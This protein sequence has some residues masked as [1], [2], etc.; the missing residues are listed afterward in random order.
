MRSSDRRKMQIC[1]KSKEQFRM[2]ITSLFCLTG[3]YN[4]CDKEKCNAVGENLRLSSSTQQFQYF[5]QQCQLH[6]NSILIENCQQ[7]SY[8]VIYK[9]NIAVTKPLTVVHSI[10][11]C[12][13]S[14]DQSRRMRCAD[15]ESFYNHDIF[16]IIIVAL[17]VDR[18]AS[19]IKIYCKN[20][21][22]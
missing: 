6:T 20:F 11:K 17:N 22:L 18:E 12:A 5:L 9:E 15:Y 10:K 14:E 21:I 7:L 2:I 1:V 3:N 8:A 16:P 13:R 19:G 4:A